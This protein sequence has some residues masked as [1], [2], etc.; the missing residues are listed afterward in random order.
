M[1]KYTETFHLFNKIRYKELSLN[2]SLINETLSGF[3]AIIMINHSTVEISYENQQSL[4]RQPLPI[5]LLPFQSP[6]TPQT[7][8]PARLKPFRPSPRG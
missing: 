1:E 8:E 5:H 2:F 7:L 6:D 3:D 4:W